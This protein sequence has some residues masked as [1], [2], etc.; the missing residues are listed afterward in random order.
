MVAE[1]ARI[2]APASVVR[3][4]SARTWSPTA[5]SRSAG[6]RSAFVTATTAL[7]EPER[8]EQLEVLQGL[9]AWTVVGGDHQE[10]RVDLAGADEH[11]AD[12][13]IVAGD[14]HEVEHVAVG[15][16]QVGIAD[17]DRHPAPALLGEAVGDRS[18]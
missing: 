10:D 15:K 17:L 8:V 5:A 14:V 4:T 16:G 3:S 6:T 18:R 9:R 12:Q 2:G 13:P 11:V 7:A 1:T